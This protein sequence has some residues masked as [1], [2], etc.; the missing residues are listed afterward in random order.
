MLDGTHPSETAD[1]RLLLQL[2]DRDR[3]LRGFVDVPRLQA[4]LTT[5]TDLSVLKD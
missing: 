5:A 3:T 2:V 4:L 1:L